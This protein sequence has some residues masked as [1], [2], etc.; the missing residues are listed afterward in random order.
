LTERLFCTSAAASSRIPRWKRPDALATRARAASRRCFSRLSFQCF[1]A[2][3]TSLTIVPRIT[4]AA[5]REKAR[6]A[7]SLTVT[8]TCP[9]PE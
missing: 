4:I 5:P 9:L 3:V 7:S 8:S 2:W 1:D 6:M